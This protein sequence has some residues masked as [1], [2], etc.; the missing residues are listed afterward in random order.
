MFASRFE[1][2]VASCPLPEN[3]FSPISISPSTTERE[4]VAALVDRLAL[5]LLG[6]QV[7]ELTSEHLAALGA[8]EHLV[9]S[10]RGV[11]HAEVT[12]LDLTAHR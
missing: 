3:T 7:P 11:S 9:R 8:A 10:A 6:G 4:D 12:Q 2:I 1:S 5:E